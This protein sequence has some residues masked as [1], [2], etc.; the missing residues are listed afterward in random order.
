MICPQLL[1]TVFHRESDICLSLFAT[2][3][4][5]LPK[6]TNLTYIPLFAESSEKYIHTVRWLE[7]MGRGL[8]ELGSIF[9][10]PTTSELLY[11]DSC[12]GSG[13]FSDFFDSYEA[14]WDLDFDENFYNTGTKHTN[15]HT[16][17][18]LLPLG[19]TVV[20]WRAT[21]RPKIPC[22]CQ[23]FVVRGICRSCCA[24]SR[25]GR[26]AIP[27]YCVMFTFS[28]RFGREQA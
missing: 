23:K 11:V 9:F 24:L 22:H 14:K 4:D 19:L 1:R 5:S 3:F 26:Y 6:P 7:D 2:N 28:C 27:E 18:H 13:P 20:P 15:H 12:P 10:W 25:G 16:V 17:A 8:K 21:H